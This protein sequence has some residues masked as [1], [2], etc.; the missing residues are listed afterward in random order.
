[1][2][3]NFHFTFQNLKRQLA[4]VLENGY[5][6][7][8][9][10]GYVELKRIGL[11]PLTW[12]NRVDID[13]SVPKA[14]RL[15]GIF[16]ELGVKGTFFVRLHANEYNP[17]SFENYKVLKAIRDAGHELGYHSEVID[18]ATIW[19]EDA[20]A[21]LRRDVDVLERMFDIKV[22]GV[23][24]HGGMTGLNNLDF[25]NGKKPSDLG[26]AYEGYDEEEEFGLFNNCYY[27]SDSEWTRWKCYNNGQLVGGD[28]RSI[29]E[30][31]AD[32]HPL[33][34]TLIHPETYFDAHFYE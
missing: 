27:V 16:D 32:K 1:M 34:H 30:H 11:P 19:D 14:G 17:F 18:Q 15:A 6:C 20:L 12:V 23:A 29:G 4:D 28:R 21:C 22:V 31:A 2:S 5:Q 24:S 8:T 33:L 13:V 26:F 3:S 9:C 7:T 10:A 25:W